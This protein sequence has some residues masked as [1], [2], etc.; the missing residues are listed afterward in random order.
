MIRLNRVLTSILGIGMLVAIGGAG[1][2]WAQEETEALNGL[3]DGGSLTLQDLM[4]AAD[5]LDRR[6][7][8]PKDYGDSV[9]SAIEDFELKRQRQLQ[10]GPNIIQSEESDL[11]AG[12]L[13]QETTTDLELVDP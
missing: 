3:F 11:E 6:Q 1:A 12:D 4:R 2:G 9:D 8:T 13:E 10:I 7:N 5:Y